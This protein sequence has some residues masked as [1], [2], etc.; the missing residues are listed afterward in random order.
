MCNYWAWWAAQLATTNNKE[1]MQ[2][3]MSRSEVDLGVPPDSDAAA[4]PRFPL[5]VDGL[6]PGT[7][8]ARTPP[9]PPDDAAC[10]PSPTAAATPPA[11]HAAQDKEYEM[12]TPPTVRVTASTLSSIGFAVTPKEKNGA[13]QSTTASTTKPSPAVKR[14]LSALASV[15]PLRS[16]PRALS[17]LP[18]RPFWSAAHNVDVSQQPPMQ[19]PGGRLASQQHAARL[20]TPPAAAQVIALD[21]FRRP[22]KKR[23]LH[24]L[25]HQP[26]LVQASPGVPTTT[27]LALVCQLELLMRLRS[28]PSEDL[29]LAQLSERALRAILAD[30]RLEKEHEHDSPDSLAHYSLADIKARMRIILRILDIDEVSVGVDVLTDTAFAWKMLRDV[31]HNKAY[32]LRFRGGRVNPHPLVQARQVLA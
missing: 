7:L 14:A 30:V 10:A 5:R 28:L 29:C 24:K 2:L 22:A 18:F 12:L 27:T 8:M 13:A 23:K 25:S 31:L 6:S 17:G 3:N 15:P 16:P 21:A 32:M 1:T 26:Q 9:P 19:A 11:G 4:R 20:Q